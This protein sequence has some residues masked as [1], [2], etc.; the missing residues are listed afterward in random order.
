[1]IFERLLFLCLLFAPPAAPKEEARQL[2]DEGSALYRQGDYPAALDRFER[3]RSVYPSARIFFNLGQTLSRLGRRAAAVE[4]FERF[5]D[6]AP[7]AA[8]ERRRDAQ[9]FLDE[10]RPQVG[11]LRVAAS[12]GSAITV[13]GQPVGVAPLPRSI[14]LDPGPHEL[15]AR[16]PGA[17]TA[18]VG[19]VEIAAGDV[20][21]WEAVA[22]P[23]PLLDAPAPSPR[24]RA[25]PAAA[26]QAVAPPPAPAP[27]SKRWWPWL[28]A[29][30]FV[31][32]TVVFL[33]GPRKD[34]LPTGTLGA[35]DA[36]T[37]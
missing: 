35:T 24:T 2:L 31:A 20:A 28:V 14:V 23:P 16:A 37:H 1:M 29:G 7:D 11:R 13:D 25:V 6:E 17:D 18:H 32:G 3:A 15:T 36:R 9:K 12:E 5:L 10:L 34:S 8:P 4:A 30:V 19:R 27:K 21:D 33:F 22:A 26:V